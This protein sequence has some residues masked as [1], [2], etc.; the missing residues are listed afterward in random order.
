MSATGLLLVLTAPSGTGKSSLLRA[1]LA[2]EPGLRFSVSHTTRSPRSGETDGVDYHFVSR[3]EF[4]RTRD[5][6]GFV[7]WAEVHGRMYGTSHAEIRSALTGP[8]EVLLD[9]DVQGAR[10][11]VA[12]YPGA[13]TVFLLPPDF[14]TLEARLRGRGTETEENVRTRLR[15][16]SREVHQFIAFQYIVVNDSIER[17]A[18]ELRAIL[19]A[20][21]ARTAR[22]LSRAERIVAS[23]P[24]P[25]A[26]EGA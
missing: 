8:D 4:E 7:E 3:E 11:L 22:R 5:E 23:F 16:A 14:A 24:D 18:G 26:A 9:I 2:K 6:G 25:S 12:R 19:R 17:A 15:T 1:L 21:R 20:E 13:V 10:Q